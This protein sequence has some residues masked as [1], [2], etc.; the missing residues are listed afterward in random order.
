MSKFQK[1]H[2][3]AVARVLRDGD[4]GPK[5]VKAFALMFAHDNPSF[6]DSRFIDACTPIYLK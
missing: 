3:E 2:Y 1:R 4:F 5:H 6:N